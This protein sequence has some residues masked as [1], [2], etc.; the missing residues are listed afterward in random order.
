MSAVETE[1]ETDARVVAAPARRRP[2]FK[3]HDLA[4]DDPGR[5]GPVDGLSTAEVLALLP[6][7]PIWAH[8][9]YPTTRVRYLNGARAILDWLLTFPG[10]GWHARW[11]AAGADND[12]SW[13]DQIDPADS[14]SHSTKRDELTGGLV[15]LFLHRVVL[16]SYGFLA[17]YKAH[18]LYRYAREVFRPDLFAQIEDNATGNGVDSRV[19]V[20]GLNI[21]TKIVLHTGREVDQLTAEDLFGFRAWNI[22]AHRHRHQ[23][24][25]IHL[26]W[27]M[28]R[29]VADLGE[30]ETLRAA[31]RFG[32]RPTTEL[33]DHYR[34]Q[35]APIRNV[36]V[37]YL[38]ERR[39]ALDYSTLRGLVSVLV[40]TFWADIER[41]HPGID[42]LHLSEDVAAAWRQPMSFVFKKGEAV[43]ARRGR[44]DVLVCVR[45][46][47]LDIQEWA[48]EDPSWAPWA[49]PCPVRRGEANGAFAKA[50]RK[51]TAE[52]HQRVRDR[53][54]HLPTLVDTA[55]SYRDDQAQLLTVAEATPIG[56][57][58]D[59]Q[60]RSFRRWVSKSYTRPETKAAPS[61]LLIEDT[62]TGQ[63]IDIARAE[64]EAFWA[65][66]IIETLRLTGVRIEELLDLTHLALASYRLPDTSEIIPLL[67]IVPSKSNEER[68][69]LVSPELAS[70]LATI[71]TRLRQRNDSTI[72]AAKRYDVH[73][74]T[75]GPNLPHLFQRRVGWRSEVIAMQTVQ[76]LLTLTLN[77]AGLVNAAN[78][79]LHYTPHDFRRMFA[80]E[81]VTGGL[82]IH[83]AARLLGHHS[84]TTTQAHV[85]VFQ[86]DLVRTYRAFLDQRRAVRPQAEYREP[87]EQEWREF[88]QHFELRKL[89]LGTCGRPYGT[90]C[91]HEHACIRCPSLRLDP[92]AQPHLV[93]IAH[94]LQDRITEARANGWLG[95]VQGL[96]VSLDA[97]K[98]KLASVARSQNNSRSSLTNLGLPLIGDPEHHRN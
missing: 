59:H 37:R 30:H 70:V 55:H 11:V 49:V 77:R 34:I 58:F 52:M 63:R 64:D 12:T 8:R 66:A 38:D 53:L 45:A 35:C 97:A 43:R 31:L 56:Q 1:T 42:T 20:L 69:L 44:L 76:K 82:P 4:S 68:L 41:H 96:Q 57:T 36:L 27:E 22:R 90:R 17:S 33:V 98:D 39:P 15:S 28:L 91:K 95:E 84:L 6:S 71:V 72:P 92:R 24:E 5:V 18:N 10:Q 23:A 94:N 65:W 47:Y 83:I 13:L 93:E 61:G 46:F 25:G 29:G 54:P 62:A 19:L 7:S 16:P 87:T 32:Q 3:H 9:V 88:Q 40:G 50:T 67:Q 85:T 89:E 2:V 48:L 51:T 80:T 86:D 81:A 79:P 75:T 60:G 26:A 78:Q 14:R 74:R 73:Q 21:I